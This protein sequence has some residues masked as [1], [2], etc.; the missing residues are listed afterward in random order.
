MPGAVLI[1]LLAGAAALRAP[2]LFSDL[3]LDEI[4]SLELVRGARSWTDVFLR[5]TL[6]NNHHL[7]SLYLY[8]VGEGA[9]ASVYRLLAF[10]A[11]IGT[12]AGA[13]AVT[14]RDGRVTQALAGI[15]FGT[16]YLMVF[17]SSEARGYAP[18][19][20]LSL[21]A[22]FFLE[23]HSRDPRPRYMLGLAICCLLGALAHRT[24]A[25]FLVGGYVWYDAHQQRSGRSLR[26]ATRVTLAAFGLPF[27]LVALLAMIAWR[28]TTLGDGPVETPGAIALRTL[29][30]LGG[31]TGGGPLAWV[32]A[33]LVAILFTASL[34]LFW[35]RHDDR[36]ILFLTTSVVLPLI[37]V[38][39]GQPVVLSPRYF[40]V[41]STFVLL[42]VASAVGWVLRER[43]IR[44]FLATAAAVAVIAPNL[45]A[46]FRPDA[47]NRGQYRAAMSDAAL[48]ARSSTVSVGSDGRFRGHEFRTRMLVDHHGRAALPGVDVRYVTSADAT[49]EGPAWVIAESLTHDSPAQ[50]VDWG[51][52]TYS[53]HRTYSAGGLSGISWHLYR[54]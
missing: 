26:N 45:A 34:A 15:M 39:A 43:G 3:W 2:G 29:S 52:R 19:V 35:R 54:R 50:T 48:D 10:A 31:W 6:D 9:P 23:H 17:Y 30:Y 44:R 49:G 37:F 51:G 14:K 33:T 42:A 12:V 7:N 46:A 20:C 36:W 22:W 5:I 28:G 4:W 21:W 24:F 11:G 16:S 8:V 41:P 27:T 18:V 47:F 53:F 13:W 32:A 1:L 25:F 38:A 40:L